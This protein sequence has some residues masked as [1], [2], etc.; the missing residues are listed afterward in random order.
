[1]NQDIVNNLNDICLELKDVGFGVCVTNAIR[2]DN[3][4]I[5]IDKISQ[6]TRKN[7]FQE[8]YLLMTT[9][10][11]C[12]PTYSTTKHFTY[13]DIEEV[14]ERIRDYMSIENYNIIDDQF[15]GLNFINLKKSLIAQLTISFKLCE[16]IY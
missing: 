11:D 6:T 12:S 16:K 13:K 3:I 9:E 15:E 10:E 7:L 2:S 1:M 14:V 8:R 5:T 4:F